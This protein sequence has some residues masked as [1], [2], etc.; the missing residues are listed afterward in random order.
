M[1]KHRNALLSMG[2]LL[3]FELWRQ[4]PERITRLA[5]E[6]ARRGHPC[7]AELTRS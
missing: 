6:A 2:G 1:L 5:T 7:P 4:A 3:S